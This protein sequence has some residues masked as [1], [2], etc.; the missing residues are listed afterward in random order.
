MHVFS[1]HCDLS[2]LSCCCSVF[3]NSSSITAA[4]EHTVGVVSGERPQGLVFL[5]GVVEGGRVF[6]LDFISSLYGRNVTKLETAAILESLA[7]LALV[8]AELI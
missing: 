7:C 2:C 1:A 4:S 5:R 8:W 3:A 6:T